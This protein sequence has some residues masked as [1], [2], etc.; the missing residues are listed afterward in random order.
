[1]GGVPGGQA[2][3]SVNRSSHLSRAVGKTRFYVLE[4]TQTPQ[5]SNSLST[6]S[7]WP[8]PPSRSF[9]FSYIS[10]VL[11]PLSSSLFPPFLLSHHKYLGGAPGGDL[12]VVM[13]LY[14]YVIEYRRLKLNHS[15][16]VGLKCLICLSTNHKEAN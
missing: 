2:D 9:S 1:M 14:V 7:T 11:P 8:T 5:R 13:I 15:F 12:E 6:S 16:Y 10:L 4:T 3:R